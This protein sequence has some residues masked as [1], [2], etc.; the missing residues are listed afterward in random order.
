MTQLL[1][2]VQGVFLSHEPT[3]SS[4]VV[5]RL[6][7]LLYPLS[8]SDG[9]GVVDLFYFFLIANLC[10][11]AQVSKRN[12]GG[13]F[14]LE[15]DED[16]RLFL[17]YYRIRGLSVARLCVLFLCC[18]LFSV[19]SILKSSSSSLNESN[20]LDVSVTAGR[21]Y[22]RFGALLN[23]LLSLFSEV[24]IFCLSSAFLFS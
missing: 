16:L 7:I 17:F 24:V 8:C 14:S 1:S 2:D 3:Q 22:C 15:V 23:P 13:V 5:Y 12:W 6:G 18:C 21:T 19:N 20:R 9:L 4:I 10:P 11:I